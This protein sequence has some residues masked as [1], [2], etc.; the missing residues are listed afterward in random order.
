MEKTYDM[1]LAPDLSVQYIILN[2]YIYDI[3][4]NIQYN[5]PLQTNDYKEVIYFNKNLEK[6]DK[7]ECEK[8]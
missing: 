7:I 3:F 8:V 5:L 1:E 4:I 6:Q 2:I